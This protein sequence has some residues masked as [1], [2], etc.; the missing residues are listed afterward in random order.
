MK[1]ELLRGR[2]Y[3]APF[4]HLLAEQN[5]WA[6]RRKTVVPACAI[7]LFVGYMPFPGHP[8]MAALL[9]LACRVN[10]PVAALFTFISNPL[11]MGPMYYFAHRVGRY[12][13]GMEPQPLAFEL[14]MTWVRDSFANNWQPLMLG[15][16]LLGAL[17][18]LAGYI[19][20]DLFW[21]AS[22]ADYVSRKRMI[23]RLRNYG[24]S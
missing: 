6:I 16:L 14:S 18:S 8:L 4:K 20:L 19:V 9:A 21:R 22:L 17:L 23:R 7:G 24:D 11:T 10:M 5:L 13:L 3:M 2:W 15:C 1:R 12:L